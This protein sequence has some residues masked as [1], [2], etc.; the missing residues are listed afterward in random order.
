MARRSK[1]DPDDPDLDL[2]KIVSAAL[3]LIDTDGLDSFSLRA[4]ARHLGSG[5]MSLYYY[6]KGREQLLELVLDD[7]LGTISLRRLPDDP[8][9]ALA[10]LSRRF[11]TTF[12]A[13]PGTIPLFVLQPVYSIGPNA[14]NVFDRF[15]CLLRDTGH[16]DETVANT[17][18]ALIE[19]L[20]GHLIGHLPPVRHPHDSHSATVDHVLGSLAD[21]AAPNIRAVG[22]ALRRAAGTLQP[23]AG[24][25]LILNGLRHRTNTTATTQTNR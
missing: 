8:L 25:E 6:V 11:V 13:H 3:E 2:A 17:T 20:C 15:V 12:A 7:V 9:D 5:N 1:N 23:A 24:I 19:Y 10:V 21:G 18:I 4:L 14:I 16:S 22:P